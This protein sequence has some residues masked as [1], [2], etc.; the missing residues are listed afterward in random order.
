MKENAFKES[1][2]KATLTVAGTALSAYLGKLLIPIFILIAV[3][4][5]DYISGM[6]KAAINGELSSRTGIKGI[7]K[8]TCYLLVVVVGCVV[9]YA[10]NMLALHFGVD[11]G[12][13]FLVGLIVTIWL[14]INE[15]ISILENAAVIGVPVPKFLTKIISKLKIAVEQKADSEDESEE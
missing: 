5:F 9:D 15:C 7:V 4:I 13:A 3:M 6:A 11:L 1:I 10:I 2:I 8:K 14:I 12:Q